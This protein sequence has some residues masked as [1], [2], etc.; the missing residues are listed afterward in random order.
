MGWLKVSQFRASR[1]LPGEIFRE[2]AT[3]SLSDY[4]PPPLTFL[5]SGYQFV[6]DNLSPALTSQGL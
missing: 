1:P 5:Y 4:I 3:E 2:G 6:E